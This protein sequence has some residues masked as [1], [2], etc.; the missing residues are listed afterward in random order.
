MEFMSEILQF[1]VSVLHHWQVLLTGGIVIAALTIYERYKK[2]A[3]RWQTYFRLIVGFLIVAMFLA[4]R[5]EHQISQNLK[6]TQASSEATLREKEKRIEDLKVKI[7]DIARSK[8]IQ[9]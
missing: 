7:E 1:I 5:D 6:T 2:K 9:V 3:L 8:P 4:W